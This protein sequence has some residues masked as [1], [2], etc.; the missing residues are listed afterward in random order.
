M[1]VDIFIMTARAGF[2]VGDNREHDPW[3]PF[4]ASRA[5]LYI[6]PQTCLVSRWVNTTRTAGFGPFDGGGPYAPHSLNR[7]ISGRNEAGDCVVS[8]TLLNGWCEDRIPTMFC[9]AIE[10][11]LVLRPN[12][13]GGWTGSI[14]DKP[15]PSRGVYFWRGDHWD[16]ISERTE[17]IWLDLMTKRRHIDAL[18]IAAANALPSGCE[19]E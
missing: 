2:F 3:A 13:W 15:F 4:K 14:S 17:G 18:N 7:V 12:G 6:N 19:I 8:W 5:Q 10:G 16:T 9:P 1:C 11:D